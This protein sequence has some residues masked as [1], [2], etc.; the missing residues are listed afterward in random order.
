MIRPCG[1]GRGA[2]L[3]R[4]HTGDEGCGTPLHGRRLAKA[5]T[6]VLDANSHDVARAEDNGTGGAPI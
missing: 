4:C 6:A 2:G 5:E 3:G 1:R